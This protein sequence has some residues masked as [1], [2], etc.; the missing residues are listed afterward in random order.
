[1][2]MSS[3]VNVCIY[4][5]LSVWVAAILCVSFLKCVYYVCAVMVAN[6]LCHID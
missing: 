4:M 1:M 3:T 5:Q 6:L 2:V